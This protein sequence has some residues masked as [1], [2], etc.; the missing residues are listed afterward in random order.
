MQ[1]TSNKKSHYAPDGLEMVS[2]TP[3]AISQVFFG[4]NCVVQSGL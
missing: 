1:Y 3:V 2:L 4:W